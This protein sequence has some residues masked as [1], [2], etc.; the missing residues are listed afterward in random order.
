M[1]AGDQGDAQRA[2]RHGAKPATNSPAASASR[3]KRSRSTMSDAARRDRH[4]AQSARRA[5]D[6]LRA[7]RR[8]VEPQ[9]L[10]A[11]G[12][13]DEHPGRPLEPQPSARAHFGDAGEHRVGAFGRLDRQ[14]PAGGDHRPLPGVERRQRV[15]EAPRRTRCRSRR[16]AGR[17]GPANGPSGASSRGATS[18]APTTRR[19]SRSMIAA[20]PRAARCRRGETAAPVS[21][22]ALHR[23]PVEPEVGELGPRHRADDHHLGDRARASAPRTACRPRPCAPR[24]EGRPRSPIGRADDADEKRLPAVALRASARDLERK[25]A[26]AAQDRQ[27]HGPRRPAHPSS[28]LPSR[29]MQIARSPPWR[30]NATICCTAS[31]SANASATSSTRSFS[32]PGRR[33]ASCRRAAAR[34][35]SRARSRAA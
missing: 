30:R 15:E 7:D 24:R 10:P 33:T 16:P 32:V 31:W 19:P 14:H 9:I 11:L 12:R 27:R 25:R 1:L 20:S 6:R 35:S 26:R 22:G 18:C 5:F 13:L 4:A 29:G 2:S 3:A 21:R 17:R 8:H 28:S 23:P 34:G